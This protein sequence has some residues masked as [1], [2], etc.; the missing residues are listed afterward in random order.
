MATQIEIIGCG[1]FEVQAAFYYAVPVNLRLG[2]ANDQSRTPA[3]TRL[4]AQELQ[5]L[6]DGILYEYVATVSIRGMSTAEAQAAV[7][8]A[9]SDYA[10]AA[11]AQYRARFLYVGK[12]FD[13]T[14]W[15]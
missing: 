4:S 12:A 10:A 13:G 1:P 15:S 6:K 11:A 7:Q 8:Q 5:E 14:N 3:G 9:R 2:S